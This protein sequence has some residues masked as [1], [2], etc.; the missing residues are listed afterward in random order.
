MHSLVLVVLDEDVTDVTDT[1]VDETDVV[2]VV[3]LLQ[4][5]G[6]MFR[7]ACRKSAFELTQS[8]TESTVHSSGS[9]LPLQ[10]LILVVV[11][12]AVVVEMVVVT[13]AGMVVD[14]LVVVL[15][16]VVMVG[17]SV[18]V[19]VD[20]VNSPDPHSP[21]PSS[22][23]ISLSKIEAVTTP[24]AVAKRQIMLTTL[25]VRS[26]V[27]ELAETQKHDSGSSEE[28]W[29]CRGVTL[30][31]QKDRI[32]VHARRPM[33]TLAE[34][35]VLACEGQD[36]VCSQRKHKFVTQG[37]KHRLSSYT[38]QTL[39]PSGQQGWQVCDEEQKMTV[40]AFHPKYENGQ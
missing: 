29:L 27:Y 14:V 3:H 33:T 30:G 21:D 12:E 39:Q 38:P 4:R 28:G 2:D 40:W 34:L 8:D 19:V 10:L 6:H 9:S 23:F 31:R 36:I 35:S 25:P 13:V 15:M 22:V 26:I 7:A 16:V 5:T 20:V 11:L 37:K 1:V 17:S 24:D 32:I 18:V